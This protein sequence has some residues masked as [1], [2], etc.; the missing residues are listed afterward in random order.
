MMASAPLRAGPGIRL[1]TIGVIRANWACG[2]NWV[3]EAATSVP[4]PRVVK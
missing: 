4:S 2:A 1:G 3:K